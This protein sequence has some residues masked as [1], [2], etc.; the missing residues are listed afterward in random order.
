MPP[1]PVILAD[2]LRPI[3]QLLP[4]GRGAVIDRLGVGSASR[5]DWKALPS[6]YRVFRDRLLDAW[7]AVD[8]AQNTARAH[9][10]TGRYCDAA[11]QLLFLKLLRPG[12]TFIDVGAHY[13]IHTMLAAR[14]VGPTGRVISFEPSSAN[15]AVLQAHLTINHLSN[16]RVVP[17]ALSDEPGELTL[18][19]QEVET[20]FNTLRESPGGSGEIVA[21][22][23]GD[24]A[25][26]ML[27]STGRVVIKVDT[28]GFEYRAIRGFGAILDRPNLALLVEMTDEWL[29]QTGYSAAALF[30]MMKQHGLM[31]H[32]HE[33]RVGWG[34]EVTISPIAEPRPEWQYDV[35]F[36][37]AD[38]IG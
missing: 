38:I 15:R 29:R 7:V 12:D 35:L 24:E 1:L 11:T 21:V 17:A 20:V 3:V 25:V 5:L 22:R 8:L 14:A 32:R 30:D 18:S 33:Q 23:R 34:R 16:V 10:Y 2:T 26:G 37:R 6:R 27:P 4:A 9:Y 28:E 36:T 31:P 19:G 13:G